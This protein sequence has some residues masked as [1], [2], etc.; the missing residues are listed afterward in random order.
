MLLFTA[1][2][3]SPSV[4]FM[5]APTQRVYLNSVQVVSSGLTTLKAELIFY[6]ESRPYCLV[7]DI[8]FLSGSVL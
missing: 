5:S 1:Q 4:Y 7:E 6:L 3:C 8:W 2:Y